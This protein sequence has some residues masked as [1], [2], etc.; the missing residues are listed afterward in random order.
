MMLLIF[1]YIKLKLFK[2]QVKEANMV[3][4]GD[5]MICFVLHALQEL[6]I[7]PLSRQIYDKFSVLGL[8]L[9]ALQAYYYIFPFFYVQTKV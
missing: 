8:K 5:Y 6:L 2:M 4:G 9:A 1:N 7:L 3:L